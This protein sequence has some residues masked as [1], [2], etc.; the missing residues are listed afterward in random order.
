MDIK[1][2]ID[3]FLKRDSATL[4]QL[5]S[6]EIAGLR[7]ELAVAKQAATS[8]FGDE[9]VKILRGARPYGFRL[10]YAG[11]L[12]DKERS[13]RELVHYLADR[14]DHPLAGQLLEE[15]TSLAKDISHIEALR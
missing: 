15:L 14:K 5:A 9:L 4:L 13:A 8:Q 6:K 2:S 11:S 3:D 1:Q 10:V 12:D 7:Q